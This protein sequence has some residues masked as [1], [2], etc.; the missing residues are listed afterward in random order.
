[1]VKEAYDKGITNGTSQTTF[2]PNATVTREMFLV[3]LFR[4]AGINMEKYHDTF[5][6]VTDDEFHL[7]WFSDVQKDMWYT[8]V[9]CLAKELEITKGVEE[10]RHDGEVVLS[11]ARFGVGEPITREQMATLADRFMDARGHVALKAAESPAAAFADAA[12]VSDWAKDAVE[13]MR[14]AGILQGDEKSYVN[15]KAHA[16]RAEA[17]AVVLRLMDATERV[18]IVPEGTAW[19]K[20]AAQP[21]FPPK[22]IEIRDPDAVK[23]MIRKLDEMPID[24]EYGLGP[25]S[26]W[27][28]WISFYDQNDQ[29]LGG[30]KFGEDYIVV[31]DF[32]LTQT[33][34]YFLPWIQMFED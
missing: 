15:P 7:I 20:I 5:P 10:L 13:A 21:P 26:G 25:H 33:D 14:L 24:T 6:K 31:N 34:P 22:D 17:A 9:V 19:I 23:D 12:Q 18:S 29:H 3:M 4:A 16:T 27:S 2:E 32:W 1:M 30:Y 11:L 8:D 28:Y